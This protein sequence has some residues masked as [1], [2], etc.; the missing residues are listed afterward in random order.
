M[1]LLD[2]LFR[3]QRL[4]AA[5]RRLMAP[6]N[7]DGR[8]ILTALAEFCHA[9]RSSIMVSSQTGAVDPVATAVAE[10]RR[11]VLLWLMGKGSVSDDHLD[12]AIKREVL[13]NG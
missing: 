10:G 9:R 2:G 12:E 3:E 5:V 4:R 7:L 13:N 11:E 1:S 6:D 8:I